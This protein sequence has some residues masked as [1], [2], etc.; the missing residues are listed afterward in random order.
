M[1]QSLALPVDTAGLVPH[2]GRMRMVDQLLSLSEESAV[3][4]A[5]LP[6]DGL[7]VRSSDGGLENVIYAELVAQAYAAYRGY[8]LKS[9]GLQPRAGYL[10]AIRQLDVLGRAKAGDTL[11]ITVR[12]V[13]V[14]EG[15]AVIAGEVRHGENVLAKA[16]LKVYIPEGDLT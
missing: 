12:T 16:K 3:V 11:I 4:S 5:C 2:E 1:T 10:V 15:F 14:L 8:E 6:A 9:L 13:G 7:L